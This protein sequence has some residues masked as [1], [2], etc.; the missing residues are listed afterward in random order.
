VSRHV[1]ALAGDAFGAVLR[2][3]RRQRAM[4]QDELSQLASVSQSSLSRW[5]LGE[6]GPDVRELW[7]LAGALGKRPFELVLLVEHRLAGV[8]EGRQ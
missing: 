5:E 4:S 1:T 6:T 2:A 7:R 3:L 8:V